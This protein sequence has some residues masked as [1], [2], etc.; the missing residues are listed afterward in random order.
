MTTLN[1]VSEAGIVGLGEGSLLTA[2]AREDANDA[3]EAQETQRE[4]I[5]GYHSHRT[6]NLPLDQTEKTG[7]QQVQGIGEEDD[8]SYTR[9]EKLESKK[10]TRCDPGVG[11]ERDIGQVREGDDA[12]VQVH[13]LCQQLGSVGGHGGTAEQSNHPAHPTGVLEAQG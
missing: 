7:K 3:G 5:Q 9:P 10:N 6:E 2:E 4:E 11:A 8:E 12:G 1:R 13:A